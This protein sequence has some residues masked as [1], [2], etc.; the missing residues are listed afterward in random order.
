MNAVAFKNNGCLVAAGDSIRVYDLISKG[1]RAIDTRDR[2]MEHDIG[3]FTHRAQDLAAGERRPDGV[4][5]GTGM[6]C[7]NELR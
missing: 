2:V 6:R 4:S 5:V 1:E 3:V 7:Q